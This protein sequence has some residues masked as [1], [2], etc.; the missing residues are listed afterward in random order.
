MSFA[1]ISAFAQIP[2]GYYDG[3]SGLTGASLK[4]KLKQIITN[5]HVDH[6]Y[7]GLWTGYQT[8]DIDKFYEND[9]SVLDI[10]S[11]NPNGADPYN[12]T[13]VKPMWKLQQRRRLLQQ[14]AYCASKF[15]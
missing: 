12:Y 1:F 13:W 6:G 11:E 8:T 3:T 15:I 5:G 7:N 10:Y 14:R 9:N 2:A 4:T